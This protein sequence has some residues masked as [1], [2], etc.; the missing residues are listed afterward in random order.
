MAMA[1]A[2]NAINDLRKHLHC[3]A[4]AR[5]R[6]GAGREYAGEVTAQFREAQGACYTSSECL[7]SATAQRASS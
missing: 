2:S 7:R 1:G 3:R 5:A 6:Q 4:A